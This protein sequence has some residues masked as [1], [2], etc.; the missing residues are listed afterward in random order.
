MQQYILGYESLHHEAKQYLAMTFLLLHI[1]PL[2]RS[3]FNIANKK[4]NILNLRILN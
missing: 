2:M 4:S 1:Q 3:T